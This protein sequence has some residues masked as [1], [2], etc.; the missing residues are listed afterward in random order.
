[1]KSGACW[2]AMAIAGGCNADRSLVE[3]ARN[4]SVDAT[5]PRDLDAAAPPDF[6]MPPDLGAPPDF[7]MTIDMAGS[8][9]VFVTSK[10]FAADF[11]Q[12]TGIS[13][14]LAA[15]DALCTQTAQGSGLGGAWVAW[16]SSSTADA[17]DRIPG[18]GPWYR[19]DGTLVF[20]DRSELATGPRV[21]LKIDDQVRDFCNYDFGTPGPSVW[22]GTA[23][24]G[25][26]A[27]DLD[28]DMGTSTLLT[29]NDWSTTTEQ[30]VAAGIF[31]WTAAAWTDVTGW[32]QWERS[33]PSCL[34]PSYDRRRLYCF[35]R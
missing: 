1:M 20:A 34:S 2:I 18:D 3:D 25:R 28:K 15:A 14:G 27:I 8:K 13:D 10:G 23:I 5:T 24:G 9:R 26:A 16:L 33:A 7:A 35:E 21:P 4:R 32:T 11:T 29:C 31:C 19:L 12:Q 22:T 6:A 30:P 17:I